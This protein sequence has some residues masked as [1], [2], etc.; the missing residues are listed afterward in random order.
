MEHTRTLYR[1]GVKVLCYY[2]MHGIEAIIVHGGAGTA[3]MTDAPGVLAGLRRAIEAGRICLQ[4]TGSAFEA[5]LAAAVVLEDDPLFN[6]G[7]G[8][9]LNAA[10]EVEMDACIMR[11]GDLA[12]GAVGALRRV[13]NPIC[14]AADVMHHTDH[15]L[16]VG[17]GALRFARALGHSD[18]DPRTPTRMA[19]FEQMRLL[20]GR[21]RELLDRHPELVF[22]T[23]GAVAL[24]R[25]GHL[26]AATSTEGVAF[27]MPGRVGDSAIPGA[28]AYADAFAAASAT[29]RGELMLRTLLTKAFCDAVRE[30]LDAPSAATKLLDA[31]AVSVGSEVGLIGLD[32][33]GGRAIVHRTAAM[34]HAW[35]QTGESVVRA[36]M[37]AASPPRGEAS[38]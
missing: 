5:V 4:T 7:T 17:E 36:A 25:N 26:A 11:G 38:F 35:W 15:V 30:G 1:R 19:A 18:A 9:C 22:G 31:M 33:R 34:P 6:A 16:L 32:V 3:T 2:S 21:N 20:A 10:G 14:V 24:D 29:G 28:G 12:A 37:H 8:S 27:K 13:R 23:I